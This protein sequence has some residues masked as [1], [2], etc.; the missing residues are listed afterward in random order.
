M[1]TNAILLNNSSI[2]TENI[3]FAGNVSFSERIEFV[4]TQLISNKNHTTKNFCV[5]TLT[6]IISDFKD[7]VANFKEADRTHD[8]N[9][10]VIIATRAIKKIEKITY[11][12]S[13]LI[14][15]MN[16]DLA[17]YDIMKY[18]LQTID[19]EY[20]KGNTLNELEIK[21]EE[22]IIL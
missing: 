1:N 20:I 9:D 10:M 18:S 12:L 14:N 15:I 17:D 6:S 8:V 4:I 16:P 13:D 5:N 22:D 11:N 19:I 7:I 3:N 2:N 21:E